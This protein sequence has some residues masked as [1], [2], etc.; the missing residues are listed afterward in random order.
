MASDTATRQERHVLT[1][2]QLVLTGH[3]G[4]PH[5]SHSLVFADSERYEQCVVVVEFGR[6]QPVLNLPRTLSVPVGR[7][8]YHSSGMI[9]EWTAERSSIREHSNV[10]R[11]QLATT[12]HRPSCS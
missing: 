4:H 3:A 9:S 2:Q 7:R 11:R 10:K 1:K 6:L 5:A 12:E 8:D